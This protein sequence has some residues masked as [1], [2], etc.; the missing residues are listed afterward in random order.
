M[1]FKKE[2]LITF[3]LLL[4]SVL[5]F[6]K[7]KNFM[8]KQKIK[9]AT[10]IVELKDDL[11]IPFNEECKISDFIEK[12]NGKIVNDY[13][14]D[15]TL[16]GVQ[17]IDFYYINDENVKI[18]YFFE[19][20]VVDI[21][22]PIVW[23]GSSYTI[24]TNFVGNLE[25]KIMCADDAD[26]N[27]T[28]IIEG[29][30]DTKK[31]GSYK[32]N[33]IATDAS[34]NEKNWP[35][36]LYVKKASSTA[37]STVQ[38]RTNFEDAIKNY[39]NENTKLG[40]DVSSWQG[41]IDF[42]KVKNAGVEF[43]ILRVG[44]KKGSGGEYFL[45]SKFIRNIEGFNEV[46]IPVGIYCYSY[47]KTKEEAKEE[48]LWVINQ[49]KDYDVDLPI[50]YDWENW[51]SYNKY[52]LSLFNLTNNAKIF[53]DTITKYGYQGMLYSSK[54]YLESIWY[55]TGYQTWLAHYTKQT[56]YKGEYTFWQFCNNGKIDGINGNVDF[57]IMYI[58]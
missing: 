53:L 34:G 38:T 16:L 43:A 6:P 9:N 48:A 40:I 13:E 2:I 41:D 58:N 39:K 17:K 35:F 7:I 22:A 51:S 46:G 23:L 10:I 5:I 19:I 55:D 52:H 49:I 27:P 44:S 50:A 54:N 47:A 36:T 30:Y 4:I 26:D 20:T 37:S 29:E 24:T 11:T 45:D 3:F 42:E 31:V 18:P 56:D 12:I 28:C 21:T 14:I 32:L 15:T 25:E 1:K 33:Y 8:E 57:D